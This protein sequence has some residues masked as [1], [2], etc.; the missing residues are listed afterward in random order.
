[1]RLRRSVSL[2][3]LYVTISIADVDPGAKRFSADRVNGALITGD[4]VA[5]WRVDEDGKE[6]SELLDFVAPS[7]WSDGN[8]YPDGQWYINVDPIG[9]VR[10]FRSWAE[11]I[12]GRSVNAIDLQ[13]PAGSMRLKLQ[14]AED[15]E[16]CLAQTVNW[17]LNT[18]R[19]V[20]DITNLG[21][22]FRRNKAILVSGGGNLECLFDAGIDECNNDIQLEQSVYLHQLVLRQE[23]GSQFTGVFVLKR[24]GS[25]P[26]GLREQERQRELFYTCDCLITS[27]VS[28][29]E[30]DSVIR[31]NIQFVTTGPIQLL[32]DF[33]TGYLMQETPGVSDR[34]L[35]ESD[36]GI[37]LEVSD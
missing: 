32:Y 8:Q 12:D 34:V 26:I 31:S 9:G 14:L 11:A 10:L 19:E 4:L 7:G 37:V 24:R 3:D 1:M 21:E 28:T 17:T 29:V 27:V 5:I 30:T 33:S 2:D 25:S 36:F 6:S 22:G 13:E 16:R 15:S 18:D 20:A 35:Q 23:I